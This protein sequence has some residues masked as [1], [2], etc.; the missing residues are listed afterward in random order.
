[1]KKLLNFILTALLVCAV[2]FSS[3]SCAEASEAADEEGDYRQE[4]VKLVRVGDSRNLYYDP[5]TLIVYL[6]FSDAAGYTGYGYLS[7]YYAE[8]GL[9]YRYDP[10]EGVLVIIGHSVPD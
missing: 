5:D 7:A 2:V 9:P 6:K 8:N 10:S 3:T 1:M 4:T